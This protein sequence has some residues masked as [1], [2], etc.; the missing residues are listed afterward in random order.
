MVQRIPVAVVLV[1]SV[2]QVGAFGEIIN[3]PGDQPSLQFAVF[4]AKSGDEVV[5]APGEYFEPI[6]FNGKAITVRSTDPLDPAI[7]EATIINGSALNTVVICNSGE[8]PDSVLSGLVIKN[9]LAALLGTN[10]GGML[11]DGSSPTVSHCI[12]T[13]NHATLFG[14]GMANVNGSNPTITDCSFIANTT[15]AGGGGGGM[16]NN[17]SS[18]IVTGCLFSQNIVTNSGGG[19]YNS[20]SDPTITSTA[21]VQNASSNGGGMYNLGS[22]PLVI[23]CTFDGN[24]ATGFGDGGGMRNA[25]SDT[26]VINSTFTANTAG[27]RA[28]GMYS[29]G[30]A[31]LVT[32]CLFRDNTAQVWGGAMYNSGSSSTVIDCLFTANGS[33]GAGGAMMNGGIAEGGVRPVIANCTFMGNTA[34]GFGGAMVIWFDSETMVTNCTFRDNTAGSSGG[35]LVAAW[36][37]LP[38]LRNCTFIGNGAG[39]EGGAVSLSGD[40]VVSL[41]NCSI[42][43]NAAHSEGGAMYVNGAVPTLTNCILWDNSPDEIV[44]IGESIVTVTYSN[45]EGG[46]AGVGNMDTNPMFVNPVGGNLRL[47]KSSLCIDAGNSGLVP[48]D[49]FTD[50]DGHPRVLCGSVDMGAFEFGIGDY[51]CNHI[52]D[53]V[54]FGWWSSCMTGPVGGPYALGCEAFDF[55]GDVD[56]DVFDFGGMQGALED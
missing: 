20:S 10:G 18:P 1:A 49:L 15:D 25:N 52:T 43:G 28:G 26:T 36:H 22:A 29:T 54:D 5:L 44:E 23:D 12:F 34:V 13:E 8:G 53:L 51:D 7:V 42:Q 46:F 47:S 39:S 16:Y 48:V 30:G 37:G 45:V 11:N 32:G 24:V 17:S 38:S 3:V 35:G 31:L 2:L 56:V 14:G 19:L 41:Q 6:N 27:D 9:G 21:F 40:S 55:D 50:F 33:N 4:F